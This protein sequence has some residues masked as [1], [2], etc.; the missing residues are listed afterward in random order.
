MVRKRKTNHWW[1]E[2]LASQRSEVR[3]L[4]QQVMKHRDDFLLWNQYKDARNKFCL[5]I[6][7]AKRSAWKTFTEKATNLEDMMKVSKAIL[8]QR[9]PQVGHLRKPDGTYTQSRGEVLDTLLDAFFP[10]SKEFREADPDPLHFVLNTEISN[11]FSPEKLEV[12][13]KSFK[14]EKSP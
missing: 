13:F 7:K 4:Q 6:R 11:L 2:D 5:A 8:H 10:D 14:K 12:A 1:N 9:T 3:K